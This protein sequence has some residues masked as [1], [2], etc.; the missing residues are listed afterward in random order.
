VQLHARGCRGVALEV[1]TDS[2]TG[3]TRLYERL[4]MV[5]EPRFS[6][7]EKELRPVDR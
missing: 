5:A 1:D 3:A 2:V 6:Q 4:G 7:W